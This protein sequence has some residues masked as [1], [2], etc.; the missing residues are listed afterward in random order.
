MNVAVL[1]LWISKPGPWIQAMECIDAVGS[2]IAPL[3]VQPFLSH[4]GASQTNDGNGIGFIQN[5]THQ[6]EIN[7]VLTSSQPVVN[8]D[9][10][11]DVIVNNQTEA[12][13]DDRIFV[14]LSHFASTVLNINGSFVNKTSVAEFTTDQTSRV[15]FAYFIV[16]IL[17]MLVAVSHIAIFCLEKCD[18]YIKNDPINNESKSIRSNEQPQERKIRLLILPLLFFI[19]FAYYALETGY[20]HY[21]MTFCVKHL[22][23]S[24]GQ[25]VAV[26]SAFWGAYTTGTAVGIFIIKYVRPRT[27]LTFDVTLCLTSQVVLVCFLNYHPAVVW[28]CTIAA[29]LSISTIFASVFSWTQKNIGISGKVNAL[30]MV[31]MA[32]GEM[33]SPAIIGILIDKS[34]AISWVYCMLTSSLLCMTSFI[35]MHI[36]ANK[37]KVMQRD[38]NMDPSAVSSTGGLNVKFG[39]HMKFVWNDKER[40]EQIGSKISGDIINKHVTSEGNM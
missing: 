24:K 33:T 21:L 38:V 31:G 4:N 9:Y 25:G 39:S 1:R 8:N 16:G 23:W 12:K 5:S 20:A 10:R 27:M 34:G 29:G 11:Y 15:M 22:K 17:L 40:T 28:A 13:L 30:L 2:F 18:I 7:N 32:T 26:T 3:L 36:L 14:N 35:L 6:L 19:C 37:R